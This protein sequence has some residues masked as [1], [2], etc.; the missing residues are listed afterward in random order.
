MARF[1][2]QLLHEYIARANDGNVKA[3]IFLGWAY[4]E[5][6]LVGKND[7]LALTWLRKAAD[8]GSLEAKY[9]LAAVLIWQNNME[10][11][12]LLTGSELA[13]FPPALYELGNLYY[14]GS[15]LGRD[16]KK[17]ESSWSRAAEAGHA[18]ARIKLMK[19]CSLRAR[20]FLKPVCAL[21]V[22]AAVCSAIAIMARN[23]NDP[24]VLG[25][26]K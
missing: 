22:I 20:W 7:H 9:R 24:R 3:Q 14:S 23:E 25:S 6:R 12:S 5:G 21:R 13:E 11:L 1:S 17:A 19:Y 2:A 15:L 10:G 4:A 16:V 8:Q 18:L 26:L